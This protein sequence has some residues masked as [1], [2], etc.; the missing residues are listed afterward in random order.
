[1]NQSIPDI[2]KSSAPDIQAFQEARLRELLPYL[3]AHSPYYR[4]LFAQH[5]ID[6]HSI[7]TLED[8]RRIP[9]TVKDDLHHRNWDFLCVPRQSVVDYIT[10]SGTLGD[11][12]TF[13]ATEADLQ[14]LAYNEYLSLTCAGG[15]PSDIYQLMVTLD[16]RFM[17]GLAYFMG[18]RQMG[19]GVV[20]AGVGS[21]GF[22][23]DTIHRIQ[24]TVLIAVPSFLVKLIDYAEAQGVD[25]RQS[26]VK[27]AVCIGEPIRNDDFSLNVLGQRLTDRWGIA[28]YSTYAST[29]MS[30]AFTE[31]E[32]GAGGHHHPELLIV[33][34]LD[35]DNQPVGEGKIGE[36]TIT[37]LGVE[38][39]PLLRFKTGDLCRYHAAPC[40]CGRTTLRLG[41]VVGR[42]QQMIKYKG[43][44]LYPPALFEVLNS[45]SE[46]EE[47][48]ITLRSNEVGAD[49]VYVDIATPT[50]SEEVRKK[51]EAV[52]R[53]KVR[54][55][56]QISFSSAAHIQQLKFPPMSR[57]EVK[58][59]DE[60]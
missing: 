55:T 16:K 29:E 5:A 12:L 2:E 21:P 44:T 13:A 60:R 51:I 11:P 41:P 43:T 33:E 36:V 50:P 19:A 39:M 14:R 15:T 18:I 27:S 32:H 56:P 57:K 10:T 3:Q 53:Q 47:Y 42:K 52:F 45:I 7:H 1:M 35:D 17:A 30:T 28:L 23:L 25:L 26:S 6:I 8:L 37:T 48:V 22:Q 59:I 54:L 34:L 4:D 24:P 20:R 9:V 40:A 46:V 38:A 58:L 49:E 31:C